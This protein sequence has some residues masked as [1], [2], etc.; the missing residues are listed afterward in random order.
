MKVFL[1]WGSRNVG[2]TYKLN[3]ADLESASQALKGRDEWGRFD[4]HFEYNWKGDPQGN[5]ESIT[6]EPTFTITLPSWSGYKTQPQTCKDTW[7]EMFRALREHENGHRDIFERGITKLVNDL[8]ALA[9]ATGSDV[10]NIATKFRE[11]HQADQDSF[12]TAT[13]HGASRGV[14]LTVTDQCKAKPKNE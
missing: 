9:A 1:N 14:V 12:D 7:D 6:L 10:D 5:V 3:A 2:A 8:T 4:G 13:D 11:S